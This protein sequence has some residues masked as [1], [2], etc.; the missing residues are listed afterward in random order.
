[1]SY[2]FQRGACYEANDSR[3]TPLHVA[4]EVGDSNATKLLLEYG[5]TPNVEAYR[6]NQTPLHVAALR[7]HVDV[8][9]ILLANGADLERRNMLGKTAWDLANDAH[10]K[11]VT[12]YLSEER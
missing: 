12:D 11:E 5:A 1:M 8:V 9:K 3:V 2:L 4:A 10:A 7:N 6:H